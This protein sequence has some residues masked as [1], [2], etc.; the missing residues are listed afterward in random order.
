MSA[1]EA[2]HRQLVLR[3]RPEGR[4]DGMVEI[5]FLDVLGMKVKSQ[6]RELRI[7]AAPDGA[8]TDEF[9]G[10]PER[11]SSR[12]ATLIVTDGSGDGFVVCGGLRINEG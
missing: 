12:Y 11:H 10:I 4:L 1:L 5:E 8:E 3:G 9:V 6:Y 7:S 2:S